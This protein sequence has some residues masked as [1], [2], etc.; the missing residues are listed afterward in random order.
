MAGSPGMRFKGEKQGRYFALD[1][2]LRNVDDGAKVK[3][4]RALSGQPSPE[5][6]DT[7]LEQF[8]GQYTCDSIPAEHF[9]AGF[10]D[11]VDDI[12]DILRER[13]LGHS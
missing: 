3:A 9:I 7:A 12:R 5:T 10:R 1:T 4:Y 6:L 2:I 8:E 11:G 13:I